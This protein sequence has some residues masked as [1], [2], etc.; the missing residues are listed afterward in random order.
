MCR[1]YDGGQCQ[2]TGCDGRI[3]C[4]D[5]ND[6]RC[7]EHSINGRM[8][9]V[10]FDPDDDGDEQAVR[11][12]RCRYGLTDYEAVNLYDALLRIAGHRPLDRTLNTGDWVMQIAQKIAG[13]AVTASI[14]P[15]AD[16]S[17]RWKP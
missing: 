10:L 11:P 13:Q 8:S 2:E 12:E 1:N 15:N 3:T 5:F 16:P 7:A 17:L 14:G 9:D 4:H 6:R